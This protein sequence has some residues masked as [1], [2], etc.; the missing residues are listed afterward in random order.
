MGRI[1]ASI[2]VIALPLAAVADRTWDFEFAVPGTVLG[3]GVETLLHGGRPL[4]LRSGDAVYVTNLRAYGGRHSLVVDR[5]DEKAC[6][7]SRI[8]SFNLKGLNPN[9]PHRISYWFLPEGRGVSSVRFET[10]VFASGN[11]QVYRFEFADGGVVWHKVGDIVRLGTW[12]RMT[13]EI[14]ARGEKD[15]A[16]ILRAER[17]EGGRLVKVWESTRKCALEGVSEFQSLR[18]WFH[19]GRAGQRVFIDD[20]AVSE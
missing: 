9:C 15:A 2:L 5:F 4:D 10:T 17:L 18:F 13:I 12:H 14:P 16:A 3:T 6:D 8:V 1:P 20:I 11:R 19:A 7:R